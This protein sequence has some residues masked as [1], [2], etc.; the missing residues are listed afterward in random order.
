MVARA[1]AESVEKADMDM[2]GRE[3]D[4]KLKH[5][6]LFQYHFKDQENDEE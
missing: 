4:V 3:V 6:T 1:F 2:L 5:V